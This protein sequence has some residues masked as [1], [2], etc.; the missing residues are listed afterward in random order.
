MTNLPDTEYM[1]RLW[2]KYHSS[3]IRVTDPQTKIDT[4]VRKRTGF[5]SLSE[6]SRN[7]PTLR[8]SPGAS[9]RE[10]KDFALLRKAYKRV[11]GKE[12]FK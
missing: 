11:T 6:M 7:N 12:A 8:A 5:R 10:K 2:G 3:N 9:E 4:L 1:R